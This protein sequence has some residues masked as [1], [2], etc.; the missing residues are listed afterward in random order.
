MKEI[1]SLNVKSH[2]KARYQIYK[3]EKGFNVLPL[4]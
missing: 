2:S 1:A 3:S 4:K